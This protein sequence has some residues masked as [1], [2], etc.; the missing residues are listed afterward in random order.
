MS[1]K[2]VTAPVYEPVTLTLAKLWLRRDD[3]ADDTVIPGL[4]RAARDM[5]ETDS[6]QHLM[7]QTWDR[8]IDGVPDTREIDL[9]LAPVQSVISVTSYDEDGAS[10]VLSSGDYYVDT[11]R[12]PARVVLNT[13]ASWPSDVRPHAS[14]VVRMVTGYAGTA[15][16][17]ASATSSSTTATVTTTAA[18]GLTTGD[19][20]VHAGASPA[21]Y[22]GAFDVT[23]TGATTY[24]V[25]VAS[26]LS[27]PATGT[28]TATPT[29]VPNWALLA[30]RIKMA[31]AYE[32]RT[33]TIV[34]DALYQHL[35]NSNRVHTVGD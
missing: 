13:D 22:N 31:Q 10:S 7:P 15:I 19:V 21:G 16:A 23:V 30:M 26:G 17:I 12:Q 29:N 5:V 24:T 6:R 2:L 4:I 34:E 27:S 14:I 32:N 35:V 3:T 18:H 1:L 28:I 33:G 20:V 9:R 25:V 8:A 11:Y